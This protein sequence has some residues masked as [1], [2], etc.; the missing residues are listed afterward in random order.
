MFCAPPPPR[1]LSFQE[2]KIN[3]DPRRVAEREARKANPTAWKLGDICDEMLAMC[4]KALEFDP[5]IP[6][7]KEMEKEAVIHRA[8]L[9]KDRGEVLK[10]S[11]EEM[12]II[13][14]LDQYSYPSVYGERTFLGCRLEYA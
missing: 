8:F 11:P 13:R 2:W 3:Q 7:R 10:V 6:M 14:E 4:D 9:A 12:A 5:L 1:P